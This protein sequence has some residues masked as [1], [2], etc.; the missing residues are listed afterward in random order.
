[1]ARL[2]AELTDIYQAELARLR[3][4]GVPTIEPLVHPQHP[5]LA[6]APRKNMDPLRDDLVALK[7]LQR[8]IEDG[9]AGRPTLNAKAR[10][11]DR[12]AENIEARHERK[13]KR[14]ALLKS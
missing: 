6:R 12:V 4:F 11:L 10:L 13:D 1:M 8:D 14:L 5:E 2:D 7:Q 9:G 3:G